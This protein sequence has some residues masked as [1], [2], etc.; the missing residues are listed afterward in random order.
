[1]VDDAGVMT[2]GPIKAP[3]VRALEELSVGLKNM[4]RNQAQSRFP[5]HGCKEM[6]TLPAAAQRCDIPEGELQAPKNFR[7][8]VL[9][10][11]GLQNQQIFPGTP[12]VFRLSGD[13]ISAG[14]RG[15]H[16]LPRGGEIL[17]PGIEA[18]K[19]E[20]FGQ[21]PEGQVHQKIHGLRGITATPGGLGT[22]RS[23]GFRAGL[24]VKS[25]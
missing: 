3:A 8:L 7:Q 20:P 19:P 21:A 23:P 11:I 6:I 13:K 12:V 14:R 9:G 5:G 15:G 22:T 25:L 1:L 10:V 2:S 4:V 16:S 17:H 18:A 24:G